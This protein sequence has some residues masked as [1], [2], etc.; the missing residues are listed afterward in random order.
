MNLSGICLERMKNDA[1]TPPRHKPGHS[2]RVSCRM[3]T[4]QTRCRQMPGIPG[5]VMLSK[6]PTITIGDA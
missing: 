2:S 3:Q 5:N 4:A 1:Q 6:P